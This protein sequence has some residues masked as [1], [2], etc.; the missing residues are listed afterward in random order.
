MAVMTGRWH[1]TATA[2]PTSPDHPAGGPC[3]TTWQ[4]PM[5]VSPLPHHNQ[6]QQQACNNRLKRPRPSPN[7]CITL[8]GILWCGHGAWGTAVGGVDRPR[9]EHAA[10]ETIANRFWYT[11]K[12]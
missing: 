7:G 6:R 3:Q 2:S 4:S 5:G 10:A 8:C 11:D 12:L 1:T 9:Q